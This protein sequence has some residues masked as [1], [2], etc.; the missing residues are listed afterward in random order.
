M[1]MDD[2]NGTNDGVETASDQSTRTS[3]SVLGCKFM[4]DVLIDA[5][6]EITPDMIASLRIS[7]VVHGM[8]GDDDDSDMSYSASLSSFVDGRLSIRGHQS[9]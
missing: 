4:N 7:E 6:L 1:M 3:M 8:E 2:I 9:T 5:P